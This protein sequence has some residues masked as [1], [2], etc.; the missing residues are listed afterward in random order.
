M[1]VAVVRSGCFQKYWYPQI[2]HFKSFIGIS[3]IDHPFWG[4]SIFGNTHLFPRFICFTVDRL[5]VLRGHMLTVGSQQI[6]LVMMSCVAWLQL[7][8]LLSQ[9]KSIKIAQSH[10]GCVL[11]V[12]TRKRYWYGCFQKYWYPQIIHFNRDFHYKPSILGYHYFW[13]H[14]Y[15]YLNFEM[16]F[17]ELQT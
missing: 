14:P 9:Q 7:P 5:R 2:I 8:L 11:S 3:I 15:W 17:K 4:T 1:F 6:L 16:W 12:N 13:K 10:F